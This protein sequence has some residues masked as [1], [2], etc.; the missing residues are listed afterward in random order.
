[1]VASGVL[2]D[3]HASAASFPVW[4]GHSSDIIPDHIDSRMQTIGQTVQEEEH[5]AESRNHTGGANR[6]LGQANPSCS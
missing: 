2:L 4:S 3:Q 5:T 6:A 1:M